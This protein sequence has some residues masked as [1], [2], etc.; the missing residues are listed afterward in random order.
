MN[1]WISQMADP[2]SVGGVALAEGRQP[3]GPVPRGDRLLGLRV[4]QQG[5]MLET[6]GIQVR[7]GFVNKKKP[8]PF[9]GN[10]SLVV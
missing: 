9:L 10:P 4:H 5:S 8:E 6:D 3:D 1:E 7:N 2:P